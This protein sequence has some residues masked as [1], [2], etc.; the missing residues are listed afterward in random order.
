M[1]RAYTP[2]IPKSLGELLDRMTVLLLQSPTFKD[3]TGYFPSQS[4]ESEFHSFNEGL[5]R[6][7]PQLGEPLFQRL[8][9]M[10]DRMAALFKADPESKTGETREGKDMVYEMEALLSAR[11]Q[12]FP[13]EV[14]RP[15][16]SS[17]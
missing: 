17:D 11:M 3:T 12:E 13:L 10:S 8:V 5:R 2:R 15:P 6:L 14:V 4:I 9:D 16:L 1:A 7:R